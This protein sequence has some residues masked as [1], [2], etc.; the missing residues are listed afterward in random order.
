MQISRFFPP[1][2]LCDAFLR[3]FL[4]QK[5]QL[6]ILY[7]H[8]MQI[9]Q[10]FWFRLYNCHNITVHNYSWS[11]SLRILVSY[12]LRRIYLSSLSSWVS[13]ASRRIYALS[14][15]NQVKSVPR[16]LDSASPPSG[17]HG[18][19]IDLRTIL[20]INAKSKTDWPRG[21]QSIFLTYPDKPPGDRQCIWAGYGRR[22]R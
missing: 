14:L 22:D 10:I 8:Y 9:S 18:F 15:R 20:S 19:L 5:R 4:L 12:R 11:A 6:C 21:G 13:R 3:T 17:W 2:I 1:D 16:S 7:G